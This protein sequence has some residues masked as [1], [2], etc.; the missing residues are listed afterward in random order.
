MPR[1]TLGRNERL[2]SREL[3]GQVARTGLAV[4][5]AP[6]RL[7]GMIAPLDSPF[8]AQVAFSVPKRHLRRA[9]DR[10]R[11]KRLMR[12]VYRQSK[13]PWYEALQAGGRQCAWL[14][15]FQSGRVVGIEEVRNKVPAAFNRWIQVHLKP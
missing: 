15:V 4:N 6:F 8:P 7:L 10:N 14:V 13:H 11:M 9:H 2:V 1:A 5:V 12:E 3:I